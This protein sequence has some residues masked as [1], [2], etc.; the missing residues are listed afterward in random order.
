MRIEN[1]Y[2]NRWLIPEE[3]EDSFQPKRILSTIE[4]IGLAAIATE[5]IYQHGVEEYGFEERKHEEIRGFIRWNSDTVDILDGCYDTYEFD[6][7]LIS[8]FWMTD[9]GIP[10]LTAYEIPEGVEDWQEEDYTEF[11]AVY[12][13]LD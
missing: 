6:G 5:F 9:N 1:V 7:Y 13:R 4:K 3:C 8:S 11:P 10:M 12:F 2:N